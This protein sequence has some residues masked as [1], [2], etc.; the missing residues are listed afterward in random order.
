[1]DLDF[2]YDFFFTIKVIETI[3]NSAGN[4]LQ[5]Q[6]TFADRSEVPR[7][8]VRIENPVPKFHDPLVRVIR[9]LARLSL[10]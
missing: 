7:L 4:E 3:K 8:K 10:A 2:C 5:S 6:S 9:P 1:M